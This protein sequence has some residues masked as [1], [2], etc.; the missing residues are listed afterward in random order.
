M[1]DLM[2]LTPLPIWNP[3]YVLASFVPPPPPPPPP[4]FF[5]FW[6]GGGGVHGPN[7]GYAHGDD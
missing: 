2:P 6:P 5:F 1:P 4:L 3:D 7:G